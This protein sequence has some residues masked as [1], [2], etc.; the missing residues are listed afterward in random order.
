MIID[1]K[2]DLQLAA[3][4]ILWGKMANAGQVCVAPDYVLVPR[5]AQDQFVQAVQDVYVSL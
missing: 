1:P 4:R 5:E 3:R 2:T